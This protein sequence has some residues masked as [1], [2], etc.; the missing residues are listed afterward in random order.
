MG[1]KENVNRFDQICSDWC[2]A[3]SCFFAFLLYKSKQGE[4][5]QPQTATTTTKFACHKNNCYLLFLVVVVMTKWFLFL[6]KSTT[7]GLNLSP[8]FILVSDNQDTVIPIHCSFHRK[9][10]QVTTYPLLGQTAKCSVC[11][12]L[13]NF[14]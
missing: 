8:K 14:P 10:K 7:I 13:G 12:K 11:T 9:S 3:F 2:F 4:I 6:A 5:L 1:T